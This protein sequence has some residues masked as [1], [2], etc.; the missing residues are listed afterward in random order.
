MFT[1]QYNILTEKNYVKIM[2]ESPHKTTYEIGVHCHYTCF[3]FNNLNFQIFNF[4][5]CFPCLKKGLVVDPWYS[6]SI[7]SFIIYFI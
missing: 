1:R 4:Y 7:S 2:R 6:L 3:W 5:Y